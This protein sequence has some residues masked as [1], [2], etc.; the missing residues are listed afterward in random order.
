[1]KKT[2]R[3]Y[4]II[5]L[6]IILLAIGVGYAAF[7]ATLIIDGTATGTGTWDVHFET[8]SLKTTGGATDTTHGTA[9]INATGDTITANINL[10]YPGDAVM[11]ETVVKNAGNTSAK[12][13]EF[14]IVGDDED[15]TITKSGAAL[16]NGEKLAAG[17]TCTAGV[18]IKWN[19]DSTATTLGEKT[20]TITYKYEQDTTEINIEPTHT[21]A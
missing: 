13:T 20:F 14:T 3:N 7:S 5:I 19:T 10:A 18:V 1:M 4:A 8:V 9:T 21:D 16:S 11:L 17:G 15:L 6:L 2:K 12:L